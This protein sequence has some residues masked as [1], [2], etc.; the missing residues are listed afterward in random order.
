MSR[1][2]TQMQ[3]A[4]G[5]DVA[6][7]PQPET[8]I[9]VPIPIEPHELPPE[10]VNPDLPDFTDIDRR[11]LEGE[12]QLEELI[13]TGQKIID[14]LYD[15]IPNID[16]KYK[17]GIYEQMQLFYTATL[18]AVIHKNNLQMNKRKSRLAEAGFSKKLK[19]GQ[20][21]GNTTNMFFGTREQMIEALEEQG[22]IQET[23]N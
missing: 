6:E 20:G 7:E 14:E 3:K 18:Q 19:P 2:N 9:Q 5:V 23:E 21:S 16:P 1:I 13:Q 17:R 8:R 4:I 15:E 22:L 10:V 11:Q 12:K